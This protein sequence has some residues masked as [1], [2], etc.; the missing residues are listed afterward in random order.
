MLA[1]RH[2]IKWL[3]K[4]H[5][6]GESLILTD[7]KR[8]VIQWDTLHD[9]QIDWLSPPGVV[10]VVFLLF[11]LSWQ[12]LS[13]CVFSGVGCC[14]FSSLCCTNV[15]CNSAWFLCF[16]VLKDDALFPPLITNILQSLQIANL[17][18]VGDTWTWFQ[19]TDMSCTGRASLWAMVSNPWV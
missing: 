12:K 3:E 13:C 9:F 16:D 17:L 11:F 10:L 5:K 6:F 19:T 14:F 4:L 15:V 8:L 1:T 7:R 2:G 18:F